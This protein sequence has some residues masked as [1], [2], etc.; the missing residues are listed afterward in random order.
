MAAEA[1]GEAPDLSEE[2]RALMA[3]GEIGKASEE[4]EELAEEE[5]IFDLDALAAEDVSSEDGDDADSKE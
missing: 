1:A 3:L 2:E 5:L 4:Q